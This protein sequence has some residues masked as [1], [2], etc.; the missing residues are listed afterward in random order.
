MSNPITR[1][2]TATTNKSAR[3]L[4]L[5]DA[6]ETW[7]VTQSRPGDVRWRHSGKC[8]LARRVTPQQHQHL[9]NSDLA[10]VRSQPNVASLAIA[11]QDDQHKIPATGVFG[12]GAANNLFWSGRSIEVNSISHPMTTPTRQ[13]Q[14][15]TL[16]RRLDGLECRNMDRSTRGTVAPAGGANT[17]AL[18]DTPAISAQQLTT[19]T[20]ATNISCAERKQPITAGQ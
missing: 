20:P 10:Q 3:G 2:R 15:Q 16:V 5:T 13:S 6:P 17:S 19:P 1:S 14:V 12:L 4:K 7:V 18:R 8:E 9:W 11:R